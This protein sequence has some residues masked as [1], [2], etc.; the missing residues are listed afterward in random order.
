MTA[1]WIALFFVLIAKMGDKTQLVALAF[2]TRYRTITLM[3]GV[4]ASEPLPH[5]SEWADICTA[6]VATGK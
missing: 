1:F 2:A 4:F 3:T 6:P 5:T